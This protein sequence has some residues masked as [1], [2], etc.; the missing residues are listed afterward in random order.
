M[1]F[2]SCLAG[3]VVFGLGGTGLVCVLLPLYDKLYGRISKKWRFALCLL[4]LAV[5]IADATYCAVRPNTGRGISQGAE[6]GAGGC[7]GTLP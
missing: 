1:L 5:F 3:A 6:G 4:L 2:R 7:A